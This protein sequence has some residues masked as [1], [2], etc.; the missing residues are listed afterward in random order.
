VRGGELC[1]SG[2]ATNFAMKF[3]LW[4]ALTD[5]PPEATQYGGLVVDQ[6]QPHGPSNGLGAGTW[7]ITHL[8]ISWSKIQAARLPRGLRPS[9][10]I[11]VLS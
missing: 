8:R 1:Q 11:S 7:S 5:D 9:C 10:V 4:T 6:K 3:P 2:S